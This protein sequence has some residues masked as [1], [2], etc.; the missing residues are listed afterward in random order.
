MAGSFLG[1]DTSSLAEETYLELMGFSFESA[2]LTHTKE[3]GSYGL[4]GHTFNVKLRIWGEPDPDTYIIV[5]VSLVREILEE[6]IQ[7]F[8]HKVIIGSSQT[9]LQS[10]LERLSLQYAVLPYP[11]A[12]MEA[13]SRHIGR[14]LWEKLGS[15]YNVK[16]VETCVSQGLE[17]Y[18]CYKIGI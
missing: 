12:S 6:I 1:P 8:D 2:H 3:K 17:E 11:Q 16:A 10:M 15:N 5:D 7:E 14:L 4:H 9:E 13:L 18:A